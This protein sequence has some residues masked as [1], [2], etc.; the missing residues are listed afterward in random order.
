MQACE[1]IFNFLEIRVFRYTV[2]LR[3]ISWKR[4]DNWNLPIPHR[5]ME[6]RKVWYFVELGFLCV[7]FW[8]NGP[9]FNHS[10]TFFACPRLSVI[11]IQLSNKNDTL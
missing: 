6:F 2:S 10:W 4:V 1:K 11:I 5:L 7:Q 8:D 9:V 3:E